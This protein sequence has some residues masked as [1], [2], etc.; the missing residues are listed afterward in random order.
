MS[1]T[2]APESPKG[3]PALHPPE[4]YACDKIA[5]GVE[6]LAAVTEEDVARYQEQG[7]LVVHSAFTEA[8]VSAAMQGLLHLISG[9]NPEF[10][11]FDIEEMAKDR[12]PTLV[13]EERQ[14]AT[15]KIMDFTPF[16]S[17]LLAMAE[18]P[19]LRAVLER[20]IGATPERFQDMA[21]IKPPQIG[22]EKPWHQD[23]AYFDLP[24]GTRV[25]GVWIALDEA[26]IENGCMHVLEGGHRE[27]PRFHFQ[28][29]DWQICDTEML[30]RK[31]V[32]VPLKP[33]GCLFFDGLLPHG[34]PHNLSPHRR[35]A[36]Q[37]HYRPAGVEA[38]ASEE[39]KTAFGGEGNGVSC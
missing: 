16:D 18:H 34:T 3:R 10:D 33:G 11:R 25:V 4:L 13:G 19:Q 27:G 7:Y 6:G 2:E 23:L 39:R 30:G 14:Y 12:W 36:L 8:E 5:E 21:L 1:L 28:I 31:C 17:R 24:L 26:T 9:G 22:R 37:F 32:A 20:L 38:N 15:R 29:R 35:R